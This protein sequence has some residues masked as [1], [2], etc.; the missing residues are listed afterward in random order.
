MY[1]SDISL[2]SITPEQ[3]QG[4]D[5]LI[6]TKKILRPPTINYHTIDEDLN[7][8]YG[9][10]TRPAP[11]VAT[12]Q[13]TVAATQPTVAATQPTTAPKQPTVATTQPTTAPKQP[14]AVTT[15]PTAAPKQPTV[16]TQ[17]SDIFKKLSTKLAAETAQSG[18]IYFN[19]D[20]KNEPF[21]N[22]FPAPINI[23]NTTYKTSEHYFLSQMFYNEVPEITSAET[24]EK[25]LEKANKKYETM[26]IHFQNDWENRRRNTTML[27][28]MTRKFQTHPNLRKMLIDTD[29]KKI[30]ARSKDNYWGDGGNGTGQNM[31]GQMLETIRKELRGSQTGGNEFYQ[32]YIKYK[33]KYLELKKSLNN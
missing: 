2:T 27:D 17:E 26:P 28:G 8:L 16:P 14:T 4:Y 15:Q 10:V 25:A 33:S 11:T 32:K 20:D 22:F 31:L 30:V 6:A 3:I 13:P 18:P 1:E 12:T 21:S 29:D 19:A 23:G 24:A 5:Q 9:I 7:Q